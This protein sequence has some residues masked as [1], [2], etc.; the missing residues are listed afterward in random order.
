MTDTLA[1]IK[2]LMLVSASTRSVETA[3]AGL[4]I[5]S[6]DVPKHQLT[7]LYK[8]MIGFT[9]QGTKLMTI[10]G[11]NHRLV[12]PCYYILPTHIPATAV[13]FPDPDGS[14][15]MSI[16]LEISMPILRALL[17]DIPDTNYKSDAGEFKSCAANP[18]I[19]S[20]LLRLLSLTNKPDDIPALSSV[21]QR[22]LLYRVLT[23]PHGSS[24]RQLGFEESSMS[25]ISKAVD[26]LRLNFKQ[27]FEVHSLAKDIGM[28]VTT[29]HR[30]FKTVTGLSPIQF[31]KQLRLLT[32][33]QMLAFE[34]FAVSNAAYEVGYESP[35]QFNREYSRFFGNSPSRDAA[36]L[37]KLESTRRD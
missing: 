33:R 1:K 3:V 30:H 16:G 6:G 5:V 26:W 35:S 29:F 21:Y 4:H 22:E 2:D 13:V 10:G 23:G 27:S 14:R 20:A 37:K 11:S 31:Q 18:E 25:K 36:D 34:G 17:A 8:P 28:S 32:A 7:A 24:L 19:F 9:I 15:Y 12:A